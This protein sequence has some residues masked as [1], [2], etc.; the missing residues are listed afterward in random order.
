MSLSRNFSFGGGYL[1]SYLSA[2]L[3]SLPFAVAW[4][5]SSPPGPDS[6]PTTRSAPGQFSSAGQTSGVAVR[7]SA[8][9]LFPAVAR[10]SAQDTAS[11]ASVAAG[12]AYLRAVMDQYHNRFVVYEDVS[13][14]G[15][16]FHAYAKIPS[17]VAPVAVNG[18]WTD[19]PHS[20]ATAIRAQFTANTGNGDFGG[21]YFQNGILTG[22]AP[23]P[24]FGDTPNA[25]V[26]LTGATSLTFWARGEVGG[27]R[28]D[29][30]VAGVGRNSLTGQPTN[31]YPDSSPRRP[32]Q[33][34]LYTLTTAWQR[35]EIPLTGADLSYVLGGFGW[36]ASQ[37][38]NPTGAV[39]YL[40]DIQFELSPS[41]A[42]T[43][44]E[45]PRFLASFTTLPR[46]SDPFDSNKLDDIDFALRNTAFT[47]DNALALLAFLAEGSADSVRRARLIGDAFVYAAANDRFFNDNRAC[48]SAAVPDGRNGARLRTAYAAGDIRLPD[49][50]I[51]N[52]RSGTV[53]APGFYVDAT[54]T[55]YEV[56][57]TAL[58][59]GNNAWA[60]LA[61]LALHERT[62]SATYLDMACRLGQFVSTF[63]G[64]TGAYQGFLGGTTSPESAAPTARTYASTEHNL[65]LFAAF[66]KLVRLAP[67]PQW[68]PLADHA[69]T[70]VEV[71]WDPARECF[72]TGTKDPNTRN[73]D[74]LPL[75]VQTWGVQAIPNLLAA[76][77][78]VLRC[79]DANH[80][81]A[82]DGTNG[83]DFNDDRDGV[84][85]EGTGQMAVSLAI[86]GRAADAARVRRELQR[87][88]PAAGGHMAASRDGVTTGFDFRYFQRA[89]IA[90]AAWNVFAQLAF[91]PF[92]DSGPPPPLPP[93]TLQT[94]VA[95]G[96]VSLAWAGAAGASSYVLEAG[97]APRLADV[98]VGNV[99][100]ITALNANVP[101]GVYYVRVR[102]VGTSGTGY[103]SDEVIVQVGACQ[104]PAAPGRLTGSA[105]GTRATLQWLPAPGANSY[106]LE[107][108]ATP[109]R[110]DIFSGSIGSA[111]A[112]AGDLPSG[113]YFFR[114]RGVN[115]CGA[116]PASAAVDVT[117]ACPSLT[118]PANLSVSVVGTT[119]TLQWPAV[120]GGTS[121]LLEAGVSPS[122]NN[123]FVGNVGASPSLAVS[124]VA[125][126]R[127]VVRVRAIGA[128]GVSLPTSAVTFVVP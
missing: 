72:L 39:F 36:V 71:M 88:Q 63:K 7:A 77:P 23:V 111:T 47:Y 44:L 79:V 31:P 120:A 123:L 50:W 94:S 98:F 12:I 64:Q 2:I 97:S 82:A 124:S 18:S 22:T 32:A 40:D 8:D 69:R 122:V 29:F 24:N 117:V 65:D 89:H 20:G 67:S 49:G 106:H 108:G 110:S 61:L 33:G 58:D 105:A 107:A 6:V 84:W 48:G 68:Q 11:T 85:F 16:H 83:Y 127:Y 60:M 73:A 118:A 121:Y 112:I 14:A 126:G 43:R 21:F 119:V 53:P 4:G 55:F 54:Q 15:N 86:G 57:Q 13:S 81:V 5:M 80:F 3:V 52:G 128:C 62:G 59:T 125:P 30:F 78:T 26:N 103:A 1:A 70:F 75:D 25:G 113:L 93:D 100:A 38:L 56:E 37:T 10:V 42:A 17:G 34:T 87:V 19:R 46:Q 96:L 27:E 51:P 45:Q 91:N 76:R 114:V 28:L 74:V 115:T 95:G 101:S 41:V 102:S 9:G 109:A 104:P 92:V 99:G 116:G 66:S 35:F 90:A